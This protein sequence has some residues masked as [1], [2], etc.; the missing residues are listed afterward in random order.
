MST[1]PPPSSGQR[2]APHPVRSPA[3]PLQ[4]VTLALGIIGSG[5]VAG[6]LCRVSGQ[7]H[8]LWVLPI[9]IAGFVCFVGLLSTASWSLRSAVDDDSEPVVTVGIYVA[10]CGLAGSGVAYASGGSPLAYLAPLVVAMVA[11]LLMMLVAMRRR[12]RDADVAHLQRSGT[13]ALGTVT[14]DGLAPFART[15]TI[16]LTTITVSFHDG[17]GTERWVSVAAAQDPARPI[18]V[19]S[20]VELWFD[21]AAPADVER[22]AVVYDNG[23][24]RI[25]P[26]ARPRA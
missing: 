1:Q 2:Q 19:G 25:V 18:S 13:Y 17:G 4:L 5:T 7:S 26:G 21:N 14:D 9:V 24:S 23:A 15:P 11:A 20:Q 3:L 22:I 10:L 8:P 12:D 16:K 6:I